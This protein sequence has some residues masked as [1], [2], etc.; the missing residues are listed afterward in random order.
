MARETPAPAWK[1]FDQSVNAST[2]ALAEER[3]ASDLTSVFA[4]E[5]PGHLLDESV[6]AWNDDA[7]ASEKE[8]TE[9]NRGD[10]TA[11][12]FGLDVWEQVRRAT[13]STLG[14]ASAILKAASPA[15]PRQSA[16]GRP[17]SLICSS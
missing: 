11:I 8:E 6:Y 2:A 5:A 12:Q 3:A 7:W 10:D 15:K 9:Q 14:D 17:W 1:A 13:R 4:Q 16:Q